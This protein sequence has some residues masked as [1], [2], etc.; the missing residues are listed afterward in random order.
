MSIH[1]Q[2]VKCG[3]GVDAVKRQT[4]WF[5]LPWRLHIYL[6]GA[7]NTQK[8]LIGLFSNLMS[9]R[10]RLLFMQFMRLSIAS[11]QCTQQHIKAPVTWI[12]FD[13]V[14]T[15]QLMSLPSFFISEKKNKGMCFM[16][17]QKRLEPFRDEY[18]VLLYIF[19]CIF[20]YHN[21]Q[22]CRLIWYFP[23]ADSLQVNW[24]KDGCKTEQS[25]ENHTVCQCNHL[26]YF[27]VLVVRH[28]DTLLF[29]QQINNRQKPIVMRLVMI[30][31]RYT[32]INSLH[33][34]SVSCEGHVAH[35]TV[36]Y[37]RTWIVNQ[38][39]TCWSLLSLHIWDVPYLWSAVLLL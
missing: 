25:G 16:G 28:A 32:E 17:H 30:F 7:A 24:S 23:V 6:H 3:S 18:Y 27:T 37:G 8:P 26:T 22:Q 20:V 36:S 2:A 34:T 38:C 35:C 15:L 11:V 33:C 9:G 1:T 13:I 10:N 19:I 31:K 29:I 14:V 39:P 12:F 4:R 21:F 5:L